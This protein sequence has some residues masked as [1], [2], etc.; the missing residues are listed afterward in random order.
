MGFFFSSPGLKY[1][2]KPE[3]LSEQTIKALVSPSKMN[4]I[5]GDPAQEALIENAI[6]GARTGGKISLRGIYEA[7]SALRSQGVSRY[8]LKGTMK[9]FVDYFNTH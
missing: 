9:V 5:S 8:D 2:A 3:Q 7:V 1:S 6:L 4:S